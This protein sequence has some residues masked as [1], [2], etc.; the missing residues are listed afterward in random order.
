VL[1]LPPPSPTPGL[2]RRRISPHEVSSLSA[3]SGLAVHLGSELAS[4]GSAPAK[5]FSPSQRP[6]FSRVTPSGPVS[7]RHA[8]IGF[9]PSELC[10][11]GES[12]F[13]S[14]L[15]ASLAVGAWGLLLDLAHVEL[16]RLHPDSIQGNHRTLDFRGLFPAASLDRLT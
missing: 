4:L 10:S 6:T 7:C 15:D 11:R 13:L 5:G 9:P 12:P 14:E 2:W 1:D 16:F 3:L 8:P